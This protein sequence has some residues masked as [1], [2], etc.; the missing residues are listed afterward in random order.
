M[1]ARGAF[2]LIANDVPPTLPSCGCS[3]QQYATYRKYGL[4]AAGILFSGFVVTI[5]TVIILAPVAIDGSV[6][7]VAADRR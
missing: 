2:Q 4:I 7:G 1:G 5:I 3:F 6:D